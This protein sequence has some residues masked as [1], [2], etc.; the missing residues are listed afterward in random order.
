MQYEYNFLSSLLL[1]LIA[2]IPILIFFVK[3]FYKN[4]ELEI[5]KIVF[6]G[7]LAS[8]LTLPYLWFILPTY[9]FNRCLYLLGGE[10]SIVIVE[11]IIYNRLL[12][13]KLSQAIVVSLTANI[14]SMLLVLIF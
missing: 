12:K 4:K 2:E 7:F 5:S 10:V 11:A 8:A 6:I 14:V 9:I 1:T 3:Y 13:L